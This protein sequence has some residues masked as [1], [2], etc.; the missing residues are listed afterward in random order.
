MENSV[1]QF[2]TVNGN[3]IE[4]VEVFEGERFNHELLR[5]ENGRHVRKWKKNGM[6]TSQVCAGGARLGNT[7]TWRGADTD[8]MAR[9][10]ARDVGAKF[11]K[12]AAGLERA[13]SR[14]LAE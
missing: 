1:K 6:D 11:Y 4:W 12:T 14:A 8:E 9:N 13:V 10:F 7:L 5:A 3:S 2:V